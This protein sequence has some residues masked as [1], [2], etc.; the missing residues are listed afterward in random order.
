[1]PEGSSQQE[2]VRGESGSPCPDRRR[3]PA[4]QLDRGCTVS[5]RDQADTTIACGPEAIG[6]EPA[7]TGRLKDDSRID[8]FDQSLDDGSP[9]SVMWKFHHRRSQ[10]GFPLEDLRHPFI[11]NV[12]E[13]Q[14]TAV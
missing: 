8:A 10:L 7:S 12:A 5:S 11:L 4:V 9:A 14:N 13:K 2:H 3:T 1:M 6:L